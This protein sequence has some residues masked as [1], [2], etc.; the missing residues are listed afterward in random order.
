MDATTAGQLQAGKL[1]QTCPACGRC[2]A[3]HWACSWCF[4]QTGPDDWYHNGKTEQRAARMP[5][6]APGNPPSEYRDAA[7][8]WPKAWGP[9]PGKT[10]PKVVGD[11]QT[12]LKALPAVEQ[13][14]SSL[15]P[16]IAA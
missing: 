1:E 13:V 4:R 7:A 9:Y 11:I 8:K 12:P 6:T 2:E 10:R 15:W 14:T 16:V 3:A 5:R